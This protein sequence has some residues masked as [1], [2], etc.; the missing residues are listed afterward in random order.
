MREVVFL[1]DGVQFARLRAEDFFELE[2]QPS[3]W[4]QLGSDATPT[5]EEAETLAD[6]DEAWT[7]FEIS[8]AG[9]G[10]IVALLGIVESHPGQ[11]GMAWAILAA[12]LGTHHLA[13]SR[14]ARSRILGSKL[15]RIE[16]L[17]KA[18]DAVTLDLAAVTPE[19]RWARL[20]GLTPVHVLRRYGAADETYLLCERI[21]PVSAFATTNEAEKMNMG[22]AHG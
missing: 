17:A 1:R 13:V 6:H 7:A 21:A 15:A 19:A 11:Q 22:G 10:R 12:R 3:Q 2:R 5:L 9:I 20:C 4:L 14:F 16:A 8:P 18:A